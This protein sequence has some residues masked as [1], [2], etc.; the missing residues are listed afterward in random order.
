MSIDL[1]R[2]ELLKTAAA[3]AAAALATPKPAAA[4]NGENAGAD[5]LHFFPA[6]FKHDRVKTSGAEIN[7]VRGGQERQ[8]SLALEA[9]E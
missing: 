3:V 9:S 7:V 6:G 8:V 4:Q 5:T 1:D 2:R